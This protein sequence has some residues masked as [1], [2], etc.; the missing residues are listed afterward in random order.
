[1]VFEL[2]DPQDNIHQISEPMRNRFRR[3][4]QNADL[5]SPLQK[6]ILKDAKEALQERV[7]R[8][9]ASLV[10][11]VRSPLERKRILSINLED[12]GKFS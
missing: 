6:N 1:M 9:F 2:Y 11:K 8:K 3:V 10:K 4:V 7:P 12:V 5:S